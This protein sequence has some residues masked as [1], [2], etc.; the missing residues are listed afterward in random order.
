MTGCI[1]SLCGLF[2]F[3][4]HPATLDAL[5]QIALTHTVLAGQSESAWWS[6]EVD[7]LNALKAAALRMQ[8]ADE[9]FPPDWETAEGRDCIQEGCHWFLNECRKESARRR[10]PW[11]NP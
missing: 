6:E 7:R 9:E 3:N 11:A 5:A 4:E 2:S 10:P 8:L 1:L